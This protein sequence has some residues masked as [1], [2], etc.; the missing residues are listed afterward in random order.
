MRSAATTVGAYLDELDDDRRAAIAA[1]RAVVLEHLNA[2]FEEGMQYGMIGY[3]V[4]LD[5]FPDTYN[6]QPLALAGLA[7]QKRHMSLYLMCDYGGDD[8]W[9]RERWEATGRRLDM[10]KSCVR[11]RRL[12]DVALDVVGQAI[13]GTSAD[14]LIAAHERAHAGRRR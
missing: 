4:P 3:Y 11:F 12:G 6:G 7:S 8:G 1:V 5:R 2:G 14:D 13:A 10:G 9:F